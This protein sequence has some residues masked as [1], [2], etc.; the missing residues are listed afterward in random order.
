MSTMVAHVGRQRPI[1]FLVQYRDPKTD[2]AI[3]GFL[4]YS[5]L[6]PFD[7]IGN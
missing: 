4:F 5:I 6:G 1:N 3:N 7:L 2:R